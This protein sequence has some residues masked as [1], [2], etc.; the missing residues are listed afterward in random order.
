MKMNKKGFTLI[1]LLA[2]IV[3]LAIVA[4]VA[5][6]LI[7]AKIS[8]A[9]KT[10]AKA[11]ASGVINAI[12]R[13]EALAE[14]GSDDATSS[15]NISNTAIINEAVTTT[16]GTGA[17]AVTTTVGY[18]VATESDTDKEKITKLQISGDKPKYFALDKKAGETIVNDGCM[19][20]SGYV[21][22]I[23]GGQATEVT[24]DLGNHTCSFSSTLKGTDS[25][26]TVGTANGQ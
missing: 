1:E 10:A 25:A 8:D 5:T 19:V 15:L 7:T 11:S 20:I 16:S 12:N 17:N 14:F 22:T 3:I 26:E 21:V 4:L 24:K 9:K 2:V 18:K 6:P 13:N 23:S